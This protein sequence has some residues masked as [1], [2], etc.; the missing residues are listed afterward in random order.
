[1]HYSTD[2]PYDLHNAIKNT[3]ALVLA[4]GRGTR[5]LHLTDDESKPA[6]PFGGKFRIIDFP[7]S[8]CINSGIRQIAVLTQYKAHTLIQHIQRG[9]G[10]LRAEINE[11]VE[12]WPA[13]QQLDTAVW[14][15]GTADAVYQNLQRL[16]SRR[17]KYVLILA[18]DHVYKQDYSRLLAYHME[19][20]ADVTVSCLEVPSSGASDFGVVGVDETDNIVSF[21]EKPLNPSE[22]PNQPGYAFVSMGIY[23]FNTEMLINEL[24]KDAQI[25]NSS[26]DFG[27]DIIPHLVEKSK[28]IIAHRFADSCVHCIAHE[29]DRLGPYWRDVG[30]VDA[31]WAA[32]IDLTTV[33]PELDLYD[34]SW[35]I[36]T[37]QLQQPAAKFV[38]DSDDRRGMA[39][40][41]VLSAGCIVS[42]GIVR[43]SLLFS[44]V[45]VNSYSLVEDTVILPFSEVGRHCTL[46]KCIIGS[47]CQ[48]PEG[49]V[50]GENKK[51][52]MKY[53]YRTENGVT[54]ITSQMLTKLQQQISSL[55]R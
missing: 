27:K 4:G 25:S 41:S 16:K 30:T 12:L 15:Q 26:H 7:L 39:V 28:R 33:T 14:Y 34:A 42:G 36:W 1:M 6:M 37:Y 54:L 29:N 3:F 50:V 45:R 8:N 35:P 51:E 53:F 11:F 21:V 47:H 46:K 5:L 55:S 48:V 22:I 49:L 13:Q 20:E 31:Y 52:D 9:W 18:G 44:T 32:N 40:D 23:V 24:E 10:F 17:P 2:L 38:F 19:R 43:R